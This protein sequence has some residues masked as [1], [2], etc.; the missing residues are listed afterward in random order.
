MDKENVIRILKEM[1][2]LLEIADANAFEVMAY[3]NAARSL[4]SW[5]GD[6]LAAVEESSLTSL[7]GIG[8]GLSEII[9]ELVRHEC[10]SEHERIRGLFPPGLPDLLTLSGI[11]PKRVKALWLELSVDSLEAL[12]EAARGGRVSAVRGFGKKTEERILASIERRKR[13][14]KFAPSTRSR[15]GISAKE[16]PVAS[17]GRWVGTSGYAY[18]EWKGS[19]Y[20]EDLAADEF[21]TFYSTRFASVEINNSFYRFPSDKVLEQWA[22]QTPKGFLFAVKANQRIT[23]RSRLKNVAEV[24]A[25]FVDRCSVLGERL[26]PM[27]FQLPPSLRRDDRLLTDFLDSL[28]RGGRYAIEFR[29]ESWLEDAVLSRLA[30]S[31][32]ALVVHDDEKLSVPREATSNFVYVRLRRHEYHDREL[33]S[34]TEWFDELAAA[35]RDVFVYLKHDDAGASPETILGRWV[36]AARTPGRPVAKSAPS[37]RRTGA[38]RS[39]RKRQA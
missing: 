7:E 27:L 16:L 35:K 18:K 6:L 23:H 5:E 21:L 1:G 20:P 26:G 13:P 12:E 32:V 4:E 25:S 2:K 15:G 9:S 19:F 24:T 33:D 30:D 14:R 37:R 38:S 22:S 39:T 34:W 3:R 10:S 17:G 11:G 8:K 28:P 29:H 36:D 31:Q